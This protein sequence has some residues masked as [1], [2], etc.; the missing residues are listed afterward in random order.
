MEEEGKEC[1][2][3]SGWELHFC[4]GK[5]FLREELRDRIDLK[6]KVS[7]RKERLSE[8]EKDWQAQLGAEESVIWEKT[9]SS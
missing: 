8:F 2:E 7:D 1:E 4:C 6:R 9:V 5:R 3:G